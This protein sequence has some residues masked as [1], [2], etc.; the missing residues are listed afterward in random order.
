MCLLSLKFPLYFLDFIYLSPLFSS[1]PKIR[2]QSLFLSPWLSC[3][4]PQKSNRISAFYSR[5]T[6]LQFN[7]VQFGFGSG[8][9]CAPTP[10]STPLEQGHRLR[11]AACHCFNFNFHVDSVV[12]DLM[13]SPQ[14]QQQPQLEIYKYWQSLRGLI[15]LLHIL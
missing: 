4:D 1:P 3:D 14:Q 13:T 15:F 10:A 6:P 9:S 8:H 11:L 12:F 5:T 7:S 2:S